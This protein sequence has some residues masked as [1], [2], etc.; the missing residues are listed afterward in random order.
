M[1]FIAAT[2][3]MPHARRSALRS[4]PS[5]LRRGRDCRT[6]L[7]EQDAIAQRVRAKRRSARRD[8]DRVPRPDQLGAGSERAR[9]AVLSATGLRA[10]GGEKPGAARISAGEAIRGASSRAIRHRLPAVSDPRADAD[11]GDRMTR[12]DK[13]ATCPCS[14]REVRTL[15]HGSRRGLDNIE[16][17]LG[18]RGHA[19]SR[20]RP[21]RGARLARDAALKEWGDRQPLDDCGH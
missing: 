19:V 7:A 18:Q 21:R 16:A 10:H 3:T 14:R 15:D 5:G 20:G 12:V 8:R 2:V 4:S 17:P 1:L 11:P 6:F 9:G 13:P